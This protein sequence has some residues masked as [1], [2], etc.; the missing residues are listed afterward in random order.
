[1]KKIF[2]F[3][4]RKWWAIQR[5]QDLKILWPICKQ[6]SSS[7]DTARKAFAIHAYHDPA[8][9]NEYGYDLDGIINALE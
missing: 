1:M 4:Q 2:R 5:A 8:W 7:L 9:V 3:L 6:H